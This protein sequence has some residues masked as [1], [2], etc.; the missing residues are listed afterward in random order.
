MS[1]QLLMPRLKYQRKIAERHLDH[2]KEAYLSCVMA[3]HR[4]DAARDRLDLVIIEYHRRGTTVS[5]IANR[6][7]QS[8]AAIYKILHKHNAMESNTHKEDGTIEDA[9]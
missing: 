1:D 8:R 3:E 9:S 7:H 2:L 5:E 6:T 4:A